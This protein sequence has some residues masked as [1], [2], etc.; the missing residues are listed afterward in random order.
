MHPQVSVVIPGASRASQV[1][2]NVQAA[3][4]PPL[5]EEQMQAVR[6]VY[7]RYL[8]EIIHPQW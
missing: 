8:R 7:D 6:K 3:E 1:L 5:T 2:D 4:L